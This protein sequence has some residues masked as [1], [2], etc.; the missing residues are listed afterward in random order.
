[1]RK[2]VFPLFL[3]LFLFV[4]AQAQIYQAAICI[5]NPR[6]ESAYLYFDIVI[7]NTGIQPLYLAECDFVWSFNQQYF[8]GV[9]GLEFK[10]SKTQP[11][12]EYSFIPRNPTYGILALAI[13]APVPATPDDLGMLIP[14]IP[15]RGVA[16]IGTAT[17]GPITDI[18]GTA[19]LQW[20]VDSR[21]PL[22]TMLSTFQE[23]QLNNYAF[24]SDRDLNACP[25][26]EIQLSGS[27]GNQSPPSPNST[28]RVSPNPLTQADFKIILDPELEAQFQ[29]GFT[30]YLYSLK[31][32]EVYRWENRE[33]N[34][35]G[36]IT[37]SLPPAI[38]SGSYLL[39]VW[40]NTK[41]IGSSPIVVQR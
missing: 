33:T 4:T 25:I 22:Y 15:P 32:G 26:P 8:Q 39:E 10:V 18:N 29:G 31:G 27:G 24:I 3:Q 28:L 30:V 2:A 11:Y 36:E 13:S 7:Q 16:L 34:G 17:V 37:L 9:N 6:I 21:R 20:V 5:E 12:I 1:M 40:Q 41:L 14:E 19:G 35:R 23:D 38:A